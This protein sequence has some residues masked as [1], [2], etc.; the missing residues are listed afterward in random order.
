MNSRNY[1]VFAVLAASLSLSSCSGVH[2]R[3]VTNCGGNGNALLTV[4]ISDTPPT[5]T[6]VVSFT[7]PIIGISLTSSSGSQVSVLSSGTA[8]NFELPRFQW[9]SDAAVTN[10]SVA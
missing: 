7:L 1:L 2:N 10:A 3:C 9:E 6:T 8:A 5:N 4:S